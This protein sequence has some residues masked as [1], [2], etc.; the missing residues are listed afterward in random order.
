MVILLIIGLIGSA[1]VS[2]GKATL[3]DELIVTEDAKV[4]LMECSF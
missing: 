1:L 4:F 2:V 3:T